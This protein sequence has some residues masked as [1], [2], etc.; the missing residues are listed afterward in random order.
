M[1]ILCVIP[2]RIQSTRLERKPLLLIQGKPM[3]QWVYENA[4]RCDILDDLIVA[5]DSKEIANVITNIGGKVEITDPD[6]PTGSERAAQVAER[7]PDMDVIINLQGDEPFIKP[8][9]LRQLVQPYLDGEMPEM[10]TLAY[11]LSKEK[12]NEPGAVKV[13]TD[14]HGNAIYFSR[15]PIPYYRTQHTAPVFHHMGLYAFRR[16]FLLHYK[17]LA[18]TPLELTESLEQLRVIENGYKI[19]VC[20]TQERTLEINTPEEYDQAQHFVYEE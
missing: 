1:R 2:S 10:T 9:M 13:I 19:R 3:I 15:S 7:Y 5:T 4:S 14:L 8:N 12:Y 20:L 6:I 16:D 17:T 11:P 18:Q